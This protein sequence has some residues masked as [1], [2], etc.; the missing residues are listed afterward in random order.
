MRDEGKARTKLNHR[1]TEDTEKNRRGG[2][3]GVPC[4]YGGLGQATG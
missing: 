3:H 1:D 4:P 2:G